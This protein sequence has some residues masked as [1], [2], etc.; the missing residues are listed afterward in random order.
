MNTIFDR[1]EDYE[2][3]TIGRERHHELFVDL[4]LLAEKYQKAGR[5]I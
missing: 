2:E 1:L 4:R 5:T 3:K